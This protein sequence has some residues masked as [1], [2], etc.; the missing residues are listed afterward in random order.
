[1]A[2]AGHKEEFRNMVTTR[3]VAKYANSLRNHHK[4]VGGREGGKLMYRTMREGEEQWRRKRGR[5]T[6]ANWFRS[7]GYTS[8]QYVPATKGSDLAHRVTKVLQTL[9]SPAGLKPQVQ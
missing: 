3:V 4:E 1:M 7:A 5:P 9:P 2:E 6:K 8:V